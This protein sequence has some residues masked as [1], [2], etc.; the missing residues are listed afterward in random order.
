MNIFLKNNKKKEAVVLDIP[1]F[2]ENKLNKKGDILIFVQSKKS[3]II[4]R[5]NKRD[6]FNINLF[7]K[8]KKIQLPL[9]FKKKKSNYII[10]NNFTNRSVKKNIQKIIK[11]I[12]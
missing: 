9:N 4:K 2:L 10:K 1:L 12:I 6:N 5:L 7:N 3:E 11:E 8:F